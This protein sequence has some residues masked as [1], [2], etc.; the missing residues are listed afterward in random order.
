MLKVLGRAFGGRERASFLIP[1]GLVFSMLGFR[2]WSLGFQKLRVGLKTSR[3]DRSLHQELDGHVCLPA[4]GIA[5]LW[6]ANQHD[7]FSDEG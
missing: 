7:G 3:G 1:P 4:S 5:I 6:S 2:V